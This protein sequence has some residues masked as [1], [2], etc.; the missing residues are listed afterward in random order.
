MKIEQTQHGLI[1]ITYAESSFLLS[2]GQGWELLEWLYEHQDWLRGKDDET[3]PVS[4]SYEEIETEI[5]E[6][7]EAI[8]EQD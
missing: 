2:R 5:Q 6:I 1:E 8:N 4:Q 7:Q 3:K